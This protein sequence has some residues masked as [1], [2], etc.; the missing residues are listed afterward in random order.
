VQTIRKIFRANYHGEDV[1]S[2]A[3]YSE[4][5]WNYNK[6]FVA[7]TV[8]NQRFMQKAIV[9][10]NGTSRLGFDLDLLKGRNVQTY[11]CNALYRDYTPDFLVVVGSK[12]AH[13]VR[14]SQFV[15]SNV[16]YST[17]ENIVSYPGI[18]HVIPQNPGWNAGAIAAYLACF[19]G[20][21]KIYLLGHDGLDTVGHYNNVYKDTNAYTDYENITDKFWALAMTHVFRTYPLVDFVLVNSTGRGYMPVEWQSH[22]NLRRIDFRD[23]VLECDL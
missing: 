20:H 11:G 3:T 2:S 9:I 15:K 13:E 23:L 8:H 1:H 22:T 12:I 21:T 19:D 5:E 16:V 10:G 14:Q 17:H 4:G 18:F 6:E 7:K